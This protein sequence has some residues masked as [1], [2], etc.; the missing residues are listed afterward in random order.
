MAQERV[1]LKRF[2]RL[3]LS[4]VGL[5]TGACLVVMTGCFGKKSG[6]IWQLSPP[7]VGAEDFIPPLKKD[8]P[9][10]LAKELQALLEKEWNWLV[11][12]PAELSPE[13]LD[14]EFAA[15]RW[16]VARKFG[17][18]DVEG[19][20]SYARAS[21]AL[22]EAHPD[23]WEQLGDLYNLSGSVT[24]TQDA[25][26]AYDNAAFLD[27][28]AV[29]P[30]RKLAAALMLL[31]RSR[32]AAVQL[33]YCLCKVD[34]QEEQELLPLY[35]AAC[36]AAGEFQRCIAFCR[37]R[38]GSDTSGAYRVMEAIF[39]KA[40]GNR[41]KALELLGEAGGGTASTALAEY[42]RTLKARYETEVP[43]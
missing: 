3:A 32:E 27:P 19:A 16:E 17:T 36:A 39:E 24:G 20:V 12:P 33:E 13:Q 2:R 40:A 41:D 21:L 15:L 28:G 6:S 5:V 11:K 1:T 14:M 4:V 22:D 25:A 9:P 10:E 23:R 35:A 42:S 7:L 30:R 8:L 18:H 29:S 38:A 34:G 26:N 37:E 31:Q 43:K